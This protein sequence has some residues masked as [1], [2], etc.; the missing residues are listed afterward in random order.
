[1][2]KAIKGF[3]RSKAVL[4]P[5]ISL[6]EV[7]EGDS[8][9]FNMMDELE[10]IEDADPKTGEPKRDKD[11]DIIKIGQCK[12]TDLETGEIG[13]I[14]VGFMIQKAFNAMDSIKGKNF[15]LL[16]GEKKGRTVM[17]T[18]YELKKEK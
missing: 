7:Q 10:I 9:F 1:M 12:V 15:E 2:T 13:V 11:G 5:V 16:R 3:S 6:K 8:R 18:V 17:W 4:L 14:I